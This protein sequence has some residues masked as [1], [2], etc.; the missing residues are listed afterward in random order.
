M[1]T[2]DARGAR[3]A[4]VDATRNRPA[5]GGDWNSPQITRCASG[6]RADRPDQGG[7]RPTTD[8]LAPPGP[9]SRTDRQAA[10]QPRRGRSLP[11]PTADHRAG[12]CQHQVPQT[13]RSL[14][15]PRAGGLPRRMAAHRRRAQP[16][17][18]LVGCAAGRGLTGPPHGRRP[19]RYPARDHHAHEQTPHQPGFAQQPLRRG[20]LVSGSLNAHVPTPRRAREKPWS[21]LPGP[22]PTGATR[23]TQRAAGCRRRWPRGRVP[24]ADHAR[25]WNAERGNSSAAA[26]GSGAGDVV[27]VEEYSPS[28]LPAGAGGDSVPRRTVRRRMRVGVERS[29]GVAGS[30]GHQPTATSCASMRC[31]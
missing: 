23:F 19:R 24:L 28:G 14:P 25:V 16:P 9:R 5:D 3:V 15:A 4:G 29:L 30:P 17:G 13:D 31:A 21:A 12:L 8:A 20:F 7:A 10:R 26:C 2:A 1:I 22:C 18:A 6:A 11:P 27:P